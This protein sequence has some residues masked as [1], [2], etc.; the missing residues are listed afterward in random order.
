MHPLPKWSITR[1]CCHGNKLSRGATQHY[2]VI[3]ICACFSPSLSSPLS[4]LFLSVSGKQLMSD[5]TLKL[6]VLE[7]GNKRLSFGRISPPPPQ[8]SFSLYVG[9]TPSP[10]GGRSCLRGA[11]RSSSGEGWEP[12]T[13]SDLCCKKSSS[14]KA[15]ELGT[16][17]FAC[18]FLQAPLT[19]LGVRQAEGGQ[20]R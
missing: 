8:S 18:G 2:P 7:E 19:S 11:G 15:T 17:E 5:A 9:C 1:V 3:H 13:A 12:A 14:L 20:V 6:M 10:R 4:P 16:R